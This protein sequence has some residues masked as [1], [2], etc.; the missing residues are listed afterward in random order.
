MMVRVGFWVALDVNPA[1]SMTNRFFTS[2]LCWNWFRTD[3]FGDVPIRATPSSW[4]PRPG[5][6]SWTVK[7]RTSLPPAAS[8]IAAAV[9]AMSSIMACSFSRK[10]MLMRSTGMA[11]ALLVG[12]PEA[13]RPPVERRRLAALEPVPAPERGRAR[14]PRVLEPRHVDPVRAVR[15]VEARRLREVGELRARPAAHPD[16][17]HQ[18][19]PERPARVAEPARVLARG[20]VEEDA[21]GLEGLRAE[22]DR[23]GLH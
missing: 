15:S 6:R 21:S 4:M 17:V 23:L 10:V 20:G 19:L 13:G 14:G 7:E 22:H 9:R 11:Y 5:A 2:W 12:L 3:F 8:S 18:V 1:P 16:V